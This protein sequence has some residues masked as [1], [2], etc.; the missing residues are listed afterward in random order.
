MCRRS[1]KKDR[2]NG[3][4]KHAETK[5]EFWWR[6]FDYCCKYVNKKV[7]HSTG[8]WRLQNSWGADWGDDGYINVEFDEAPR[9]G[10]C[11]MN[12]YVYRVEPNLKGNRFTPPASETATDP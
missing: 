2:E 6:G 3:A 1:S 10:W 12:N 4:C 9:S 7:S 8:V 5:N 11:N